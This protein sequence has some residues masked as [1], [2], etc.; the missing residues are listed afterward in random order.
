[1]HLTYGNDFWRILEVK[2]IEPS[3]FHETFYQA[4]KSDF[5]LFKTKRLFVEIFV[6]FFITSPRQGIPM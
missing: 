2:A 1:M 5:G 6:S 4:F 3:I